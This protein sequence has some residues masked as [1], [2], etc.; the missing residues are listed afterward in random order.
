M[1]SKLT[2]KTIRYTL[3][4]HLSIFATIWLY[5]VFGT[6]QAAQLGRACGVDVLPSEVAFSVAGSVCYGLLLVLGICLEMEEQSESLIARSFTDAG[7]LYWNVLVPSTIVAF[8]WSAFVVLVISVRW[9]ADLATV[10][11]F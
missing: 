1:S 2:S 9:T 10:C 11:L 8:I 6:I 3:G 5:A 7:R 4:T